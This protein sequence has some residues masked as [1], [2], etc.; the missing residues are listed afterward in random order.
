MVITRK[1]AYPNP[2]EIPEGRWEVYLI[3]LPN[4]PYSTVNIT[5][6]PLTPTV[7]VSPPYM[8]FEPALWNVPQEL[9]VLAF[10]D[11]D[12]LVTP[13]QSAIQLIL[14]SDDSNYHQRQ[15]PD[16]NVTMEDNDDGGFSEHIGVALDQG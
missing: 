13:Y 15:L 10:E 4:M 14:T 2:P 11:L 1:E 9:T 7:G 16:L 8:V 12:N 5:F 3:T 6:N